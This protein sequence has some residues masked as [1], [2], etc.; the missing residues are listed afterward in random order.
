EPE[1]RVGGD[2]VDALVRPPD[3][4]ARPDHRLHLGVRAPRPAAPLLELDPQRRD[5][6]LHAADPVVLAHAQS[7][8]RR[9]SSIP[10]PAPRPKRTGEGTTA[11]SATRSWQARETRPV[12]RGDRSPRTSRTNPW[13]RPTESW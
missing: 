3:P 8:F 6:E 1:R 13:R 4:E 12:H 5:V 9:R 11:G 10:R 2:G 7:S